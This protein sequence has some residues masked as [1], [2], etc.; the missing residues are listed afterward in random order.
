MYR[1]MLSL[2][3]LPTA[4]GVSVGTGRAESSLAD[5]LRSRFERSRIEVQSTSDE[6]RVVKKG[7]ILLLQADQVPAARLRVVQA[8][9]KSPRFH[10]PH[11]ARVEVRDRRLIATPGELSL[12]KGTRMAV[13]DVKVSGDQ[14]RLFDPVRL[15]NGTTTHGCTEF[16]FVL[17]PATADRADAQAVAGLIDHWLTIDPAS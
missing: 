11:Y 10:S 3:A 12:P 7:T 17:D 13:L 9:M 4:L 8:N 2:I 15:A 1:I 5:A 16:V 6:G 14:V